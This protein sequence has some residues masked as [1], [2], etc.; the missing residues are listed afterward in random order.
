M[1]PNRGCVR[2]GQISLGLLL[3]LSVS[4]SL[5][6][7]DNNWPQFRGPLATGVS[8][9]PALPDTWS[10]TENVLWR[11]E[12]PGR[13]WSSPI[14]WGDQVFITTVT[15]DQETREKVKQRGLYLGGN[16]SEPSK[17]VHQWRVRCHDLATGQLQWEK[18][19][20]DGPPPESIHLKN[21]Y[22]SET[23]VT[24]G[25]RV[26]VYF[27]N[28]GVYCYTLAGA[29]VWS[30][31][32]G[33]YKTAAGWGTGGSPML[34]QDRLYVVCD[35]EEQSFLV[36][37]DSRT[38]EEVWRTPRPEKS[39]WST[40]YLWQNDKRTELVV[41]G[42]GMV[43]S[44]DLDGHE[45][46]NLGD[47]SGNAIPTPMSGL[48]LLFVSSGHVMGTKKPIMAVRPGASGDITLASS[49]TSNDSVAWCLR[50]AAPY[51]PSILLYKGNIHVITDVGFVACYDGRTGDT[52]YGKKRLPNGRA[53]TASPWAY[54]DQV[55]ALNEYGDT[56]VIKAGSEFEVLRVNSLSD[57]EMFLATPA[58][59]GDK[60]LIRSDRTLYAIQK[61][62]AAAGAG[63]R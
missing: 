22:A 59:T 36:A 51:N 8:D 44:Y 43:R 17:A 61:G 54:N 46:W 24:D 23:P 20:H 31:S 15:N 53:F 62:A 19:A 18:I 39:S 63:G 45:L 29:P 5:H 12:V 6:A 57:D 4:T 58:V 40:P 32:L 60:L 49:A 52:V 50:Q 56:F 16:R 42:S 27:G 48:G 7:A 13:G 35:N 3:C 10:A 2:A 38:G 9:N 14:V 41:S 37:L 28:L 33:A 34:Y 21:T 11:A 25:E 1:N 26:Y 30:H 47:M 55:F